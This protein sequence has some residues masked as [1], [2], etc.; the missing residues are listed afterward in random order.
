MAGYSGTPLAKKLGIKEG[1]K[2]LLVNR[3]SH[4]FE[5]FDDFPIDALVHESQTVDVY[6]IIHFF[7][8]SKDDLHAQLPK[9]K[10]KIEQNGMIWVSWPKGKSKIPKDLI[11]DD[12]R[13]LMLTIDMV[14]VKVCA[15]DDDWSGLKGVIRVEKRKV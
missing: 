13:N 14:D 11:E 1:S 6:D 4:Y 10:D 15:V 3:P 9:L 12:I 2:V 5:L 8:T 7:T